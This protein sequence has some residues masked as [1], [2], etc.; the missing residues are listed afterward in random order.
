[1]IRCRAGVGL[2]DLVMAVSLLA[3]LFSILYSGVVAIRQ[4]VRAL[5]YRA[6]AGLSGAGIHGTLLSGVVIDSPGV[7]ANQ[8][9]RPPGRHPW[10]HGRLPTPRFPSMRTA[11]LKVHWTDPDGGPE[12]QF[13]ALAPCAV[14]TVRERRFQLNGPANGHGRAG[15][16]LVEF[17]HQ[18]CPPADRRGRRDLGHD[19]HLSNEPHDRVGAG[20]AGPQCLYHDAPFGG[21]SSF[22]GLV[23]FVPAGQTAYKDGLLSRGFKI[24]VY[25]T[26]IGRGI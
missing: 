4:Q 13:S 6:R 12:H 17:P 5:G 2:I 22:R 21:F 16:T 14:P 24:N 8:R 19:P 11:V 18:F 3:A 10:G 7:M 26:T 23:R 1:M 9:D 20:S 25:E 15:F